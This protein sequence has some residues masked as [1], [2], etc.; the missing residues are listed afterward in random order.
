[1]NSKRKGSNNELELAAFLRVKGLNVWRDSGSGSGTREKGDLNNDMGFTM[2][3][4]CGKS[5]NLWKAWQQVDYASTMNRGIPVLIIRRDGMA[6]YDWLVVM[7]I[8]DWVAQ[9][10]GEK[11]GSTYE[12][13]KIKYAAQKLKQ[14]A[15]DMMKYLP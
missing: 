8:E 4:K 7:H 9:I 12:D 11:V 13:P 14:A 5:I 6:K 15:H 3:A 2:E 10:Q 1:M